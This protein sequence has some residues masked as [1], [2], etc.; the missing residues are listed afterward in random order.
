MAIAQFAPLLS[1][2]FHY[3]AEQKCYGPLQTVDRDLAKGAGIIF[4]FFS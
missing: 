1:Y 4:T 2:C 3:Q